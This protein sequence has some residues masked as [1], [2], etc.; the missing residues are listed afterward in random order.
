MFITSCVSKL[1]LTCLD[2]MKMLPFKLRKHAPDKCCIL[3]KGLELNDILG[4]HTKW[5]YCSF[6]HEVP[7]TATLV[8]FMTREYKAGVA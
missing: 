5:R 3:V 8:I 1:C 2:L 7:M 6:Q 4:H